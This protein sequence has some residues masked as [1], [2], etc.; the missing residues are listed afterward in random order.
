[1]T[2]KSLLVLVLPCLAMAAIGVAA[3]HDSCPPLQPK[4]TDRP[5][6]DDSLEDMW[7]LGDGGY[8]EW[9]AVGGGLLRLARTPGGFERA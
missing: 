9:T 4:I 5:L 3:W 8:A 6:Y 7:G 1:M 2:R